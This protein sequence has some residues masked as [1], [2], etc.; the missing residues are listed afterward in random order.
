M[1]FATYIVTAVFIGLIAL[2]FLWGRPAFAVTMVAVATFGLAPLF[3][4]SDGIPAHADGR[5]AAEQW[6][7]LAVAPLPDNVFIVIL[8]FADDDIRTYRLVLPSGQQRDKFLE[9]QRGL[10]AGKMMMGKARKGRAG[11]MSDSEMDFDFVEAPQATKEG[12]PP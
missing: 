10:K 12:S 3:Q 7:L 2:L 4:A 11:L 6:K 1:M 9:A 5:L 8:R